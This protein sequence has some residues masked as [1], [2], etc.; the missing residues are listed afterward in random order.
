[1]PAGALLFLLLIDISFVSKCRWSIDSFDL[2]FCLDI[3]G[4][5]RTDWVMRKKIQTQRASHLCCIIFMMV[6]IFKW[7]DN[8]S[9]IDV[10]L[11]VAG[12]TY[13]PLLGMFLLVSWQ[14]EKSMTIWSSGFVSPH[15]IDTGESIWWIIWLVS[16]SIKNQWFI[17]SSC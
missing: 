11:K 2:V 16:K 10:I 4:I 7:I 17:H 3:R 12:F 13:G 14:T 5:N 6:M 15:L 1:M 9:I 8:K